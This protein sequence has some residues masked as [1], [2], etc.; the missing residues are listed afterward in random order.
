MVLSGAG[1]GVCS[2]TYVD[3]K[4][5]TCTRCLDYKIH[6]RS[7]EK[8]KTVNEKILDQMCFLDE[9]GKPIKN[10]SLREMI[11]MAKKSEYG[12]VWYSEKGPIQITKEG[13]MKPM[14]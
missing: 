11:D 10:Y 4:L 12:C 1:T 8:Q 2:I 7:L 9:Q 6:I 13:D 5:C 3:L 14:W